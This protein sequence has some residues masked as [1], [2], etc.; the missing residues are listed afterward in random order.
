MTGSSAHYTRNDVMVAVRIAY[1][2]GIIETMSIY[3]TG[4]VLPGGLVGRYLDELKLYT[5]E[6]WN[7]N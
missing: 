5:K 1:L 3:E 6:E 4:G 7:G 2:E